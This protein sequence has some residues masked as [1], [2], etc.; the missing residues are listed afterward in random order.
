MM[1]LEP[2]LLSFTTRYQV[3]V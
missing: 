3:M 1:V 2:I